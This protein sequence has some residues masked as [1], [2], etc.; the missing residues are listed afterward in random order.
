MPV[1]PRQSFVDRYGDPYQTKVPDGHYRAGYLGFETGS[2]YGQ[3][4][5][6]AWFLITEEGPHHGKP[7]VRFYNE[8]AR[9]WIP[10]SH[11]LFLDFSALTGLRPPARFTPDDFLKGTEV[12][13]AV[14]TVRERIQGK[15]R[16]E[17]PGALH[18]SKI[19]RLLKY[20]AGSPPCARSEE[21]K[22]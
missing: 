11:N 9:A 13:A 17:L 19:E 2:P 7:I 20:T 21:K 6:F 1:K 3:K 12:L 15:R 10:R 22:K 18:Y 14:I 4:R 5:N 16:I 8:P